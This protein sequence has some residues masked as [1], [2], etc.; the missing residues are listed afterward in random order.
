MILHVSLKGRAGERHTGKNERRQKPGQERLRQSL[1]EGDTENECVRQNERLRKGRET[2]RE[3][4]KTEG[5][6][7][8]RH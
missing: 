1:R 2:H 4:R 6:E 8:D 5:E 7:T 3:E